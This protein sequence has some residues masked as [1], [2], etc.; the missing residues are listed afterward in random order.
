[1]IRMD[2]LKIC[3]SFERPSVKDIVSIVDRIGLVVILIVLYPS[4]FGTGIKSLVGE[5]Q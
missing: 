5:I 4:S 3:H 2:I 1:V